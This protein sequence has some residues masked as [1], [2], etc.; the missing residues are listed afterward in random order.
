VLGAQ[1]NRTFDVS[2]LVAPRSDLRVPASCVEAGRW[3]SARQA[4]TFAPGP[5]AAYP[6]LRRIK[7]RQAREAASVG[8]EARADQGAV[9]ADVAARSA[10]LD[11]DSETGAMHDVFEGRREG[12]L[13]LTSRV[14]LH[15]D[16][17]GAHVAIGGAFEVL[18]HVSLPQVFA[19][20]HGPSWRA[21]PST[22]STARRPPMRR[23]G[24]EPRPSSS[25]CW[26]RAS[27]SAT[28]SA[29]GGTSA[30]PPRQSAAP[31]SS[32]ARSLTAF[33]EPAAGAEVRTRPIRRPSRRRR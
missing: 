12:L 31:G 10:A 26:A 15:P 3:D 2:V 19:S 13:A 20:L 8:L 33:G 23:R 16:P 1:Q 22:R 4:E 27:R 24:R 29:S 11:V 28:G 25:G 7:N 18:D 30:S 9:W 32:A 17:V 14:G 21:T 6:A 5:Q